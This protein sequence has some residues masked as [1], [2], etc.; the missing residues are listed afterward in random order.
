MKF[1]RIDYQSGD[2]DW[3]KTDLHPVEKLETLLRLY[4]KRTACVWVPA[5]RSDGFI[6]EVVFFQFAAQSLE[7]EAQHTR[8]RWLFSTIST[9]LLKKHPRVALAFPGLVGPD[10]AAFC[11]RVEKEREQ[12]DL[13]QRQKAKQKA[14]NR[15]PKKRADRKIKHFNLALRETS[16]PGISPLSDRFCIAEIFFEASQLRGVG[17]PC[18]AE[19]AR[20]HGHP[21]N[22]IAWR[23]RAA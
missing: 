15:K 1:F 14:A 16:E 5:Y 12:R 2:G 21:K 18:E 3:L 13:R 6:D 22:G 9:F 11:R 20:Y 10:V 19:F 17:S 7:G 8:I 4:R 23:Q